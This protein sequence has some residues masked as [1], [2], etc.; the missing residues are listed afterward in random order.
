MAVFI[1][2]W[3]NKSKNQRL[4]CVDAEAQEAKGKKGGRKPRRPT[5]VNRSH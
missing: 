1:G 2:H 3:D 4:L 5:A